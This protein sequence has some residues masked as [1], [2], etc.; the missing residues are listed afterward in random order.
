[1]KRTFT[2]LALLIAS[3]AFAGD[4]TLSPAAIMLRGES[5]QSTTQTLALTNGTSRSMTFALDAQDVVVRDG[6]REFAPAGRIAGSIAATAVF[7]R[8]TITVRPGEREAVHV[9]LTIPAD[10][11]SRAVMI[12]FHGADRIRNGN[13]MMTASLGA[14]ITFTLSDRAE[15]HADALVVQ[16]QTPTANLSVAQTC[17]N[18]GTEPLVAK[19]MVAILGANGTVQGK[20]ALKP[21]R[22]LPGERAQLGTE[23]AAE[24]APGHYRVLVTYDY[25]GGALTQSAEVDVR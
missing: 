19:G 24:L 20:A 22:L 12:L 3:S 9:T 1:M 2:F 15:L 14:L 17:T 23:Y 21:R 10:V 5:G 7:S 13:M 16:P 4:L 6:R 18:S 25:E 8:N 11:Q